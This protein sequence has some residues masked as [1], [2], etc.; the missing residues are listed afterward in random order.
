MVFDLIEAIQE[1]L[2]LQLNKNILGKKDKEKVKVSVLREFQLWGILSWPYNF[3][4]LFESTLQKVQQEPGEFEEYNDTLDIEVVCD[5]WGDGGTVQSWESLENHNNLSTKSS[6]DFQSKLGGK[7]NNS[8][9]K[10]VGKE[11]KVG[12]FSKEMEKKGKVEENEGEVE[13]LE[14]STDSESK[15]ESRE[16]LKSGKS[17]ES[18][19]QISECS[20]DF[21]SD[22]SLSEEDFL[23]ALQICRSSKGES[24]GSSTNEVQ[25]QDLWRFYFLPDISKFLP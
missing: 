4:A 19:D 25:K 10:K 21:S 8:G 13:D 22:S 16:D 24:N 11:G 15:A 17:E 18:E 5:W 2:S 7:V 3:Q 1:F 9:A 12:N 20:E 23:E 14:G 6:K